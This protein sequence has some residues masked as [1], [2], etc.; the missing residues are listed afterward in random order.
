MG[1]RG[2]EWSVSAECPTCG[3]SMR[4]DGDVLYCSYLK[5][6]KYAVLYDMGMVLVEVKGA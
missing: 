1:K 2:V 6:E 4:T 5:C 3:Y